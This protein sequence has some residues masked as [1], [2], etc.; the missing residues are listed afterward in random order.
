MIPGTSISTRSRLIINW[1][2]ITAVSSF[3]TIL[4][5]NERPPVIVNSPSLL[6][7]AFSM[8]SFGTPTKEQA[9]GYIATYAL[10]Q[11]CGKK[12]E[13]IYLRLPTLWRA[14]WAELVE[15]ARLETERKEREILRRLQ[16]LLDIG[17][18]E[19]VVEELNTAEKK[20][21]RVTKDD[22]DKSSEEVQDVNPSKLER[23]YQTDMI[24][25]S[26]EY[27]KNTPEYLHML[28]GRKQLPMWAFKDEVLAA[29]DR[30]QVVIICGETGW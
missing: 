21:K 19:Y 6:S 8:N 12:E 13:K 23:S 27:K 3:K 17:S 2:S 14:L 16:A 7:T 15:E 10:F 22:L 1:S 4:N 29:I 26:W 5:S 18:N 30:E 28:N 25:E 9:E 11:L 24:R 20:K